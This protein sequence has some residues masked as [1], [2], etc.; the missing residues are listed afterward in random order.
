MGL[1]VFMGKDIMS[2]LYFEY[3]LAGMEQ[4]HKI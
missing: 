4:L 1:G 2:L 3:H